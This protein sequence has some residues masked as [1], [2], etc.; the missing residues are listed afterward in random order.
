MIFK[1][2]NFLIFASIL[3]YFLRK[4]AGEFWRDRHKKIGEIVSSAEAAY[5]TA[6]EEEKDWNNKFKDIG[7]E[8]SEL[9]Q[10]LKKEGEMERARIMKQARHYAEQLKKDAHT[11]GEYETELAIAEIKKI[12]VE[13]A[14]E[15]ATKRLLRETTD[16]EHAK[17]ANSALKEIELSI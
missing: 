16:E 7:M 2:I 9:T 3:G 8:I 10:E 5:K 13:M 4:P 17:I 6:F 1:L 15:L 11:S 14:V 12:T